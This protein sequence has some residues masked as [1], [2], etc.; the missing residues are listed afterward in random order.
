MK[1]VD[2]AIDSVMRSREDKGAQGAVCMCCTMVEK[3][4]AEVRR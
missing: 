1:T 4:D 3:G 2:W